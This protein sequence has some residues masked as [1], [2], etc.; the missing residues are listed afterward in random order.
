MIYLKNVGSLAIIINIY[1]INTN[2][3][4]LNNVERIDNIYIEIPQCNTSVCFMNT[5]CLNLMQQN[6]P[7]KWKSNSFRSNMA[8]YRFCQFHP[9]YV[10]GG[11]DYIRECFRQ[12][13]LNNKIYKSSEFRPLC[14]CYY[15]NFIF[16]IK[17]L[18]TLTMHHL[19]NFQS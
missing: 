13:L 12:Y 4:D 9:R 7:R 1:F 16:S 3:K 6:E 15:S 17:S 14:S 18:G 11:N 19:Y 5:Y 2:L 8:K 10:S